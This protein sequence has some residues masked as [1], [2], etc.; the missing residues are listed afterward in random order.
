MPDPAGRAAEQ[1]RD[2][3]ISRE[4]LAQMDEAA[5]SREHWKIL[6][7]AGMGFFTD[8]YDLFIIGV[9][10]TMIVSEWHIASYQKSLLTSLALL[11]SAAG[12]V[13]FGHIA[14]RFG[15][16]KVY[17]YEVLVLAAGAIASAFAPGIWWLIT[18]T[19]SPVR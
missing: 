1:A 4:L 5:T 15:R 14:D 19:P 3:E 12:A 7:T 18:A 13:F 6:L 9:A 16:R 17:G 11:T 8:A 10:A 2:S